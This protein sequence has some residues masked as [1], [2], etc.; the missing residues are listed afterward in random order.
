MKY[1]TVIFDFD[2]T[3]LYT[4]QDLADAVNHA[5]ARRGYPTHSVRAIER[6]IG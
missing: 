6:M 1:E 3:L 2:G 5:V 4:V